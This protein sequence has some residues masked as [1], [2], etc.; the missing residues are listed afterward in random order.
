MVDMGPISF[1]LGLKVEQDQERKTNKL[2]QPAYIKKSLVKFQLDKANS[3]NTPMKESAQLIQCTEREAL[4]S[5]KERYQ[6]MIRAIMFSMVEIR[7]DIAYTTLLVSRFAQNP[8]HQH[9]E[10]VKTIL[11]YLKGLKN[12]GITYGGE[13]KLKIKG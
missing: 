8:S 10:A 4:P 6:G 9:I 3:M 13:K 1:Y 12:R 11:K 2:S 7:L 5:E